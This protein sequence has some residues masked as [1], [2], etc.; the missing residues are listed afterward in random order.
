MPLVAFGRHTGFGLS[1][2]V[3]SGLFRTCTSTDQI[4]LGV[5]SVRVGRQ[6][7]LSI[8]LR[9]IRHVL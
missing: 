7:N 1:I 2:L 8:A 3:P 5:M 6:F 4:C 9:S